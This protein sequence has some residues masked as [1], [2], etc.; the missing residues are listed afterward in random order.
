MPVLDPIALESDVRRASEGDRPAFARLIDATRTTVC[1]VALAIVR[2]VEASEDVA[3]DVYLHA[4]RSLPSLKSSASFLPWLRQLTR[5]RAHAYLRKDQPARRTNL[6]ETLATVLTD[7]RPSAEAEMLLSEERQAIRTGLDELP[8]E[9][10]EVLI[11]FYR[12]E[13]SVR[14]VANLLDLS[15]SA[16]KKRLE[17]AR[18]ALR[19]AVER[20]LS[21]A[22]D[23]TKPGA[24][25]SVTVLAMIPP[26]TP[27]IAATA[28][29]ALGAAGLSKLVAVLGS[30]ALSSLLGVVSV[31][32]GVRC[33]MRKAKE[34]SERQALRRVAVW[35]VA[36][37]A[38]LGAAMPFAAHHSERPL[39]ILA[40]FGTFLTFLWA[41]SI[42]FPAR[43]YAPRKA[44]ERAEDPTAV[45]RQRRERWRANI[46]FTL[47][48]LIGSLSIGWTI[49][50][51][52]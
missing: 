17:R 13:Q 37:M 44:R 50:H 15:E 38:L 3:Q 9:A 25:F 42:Y 1:S 19:D 36:G 31:L 46:A 10:R 40:W 49:L 6:D 32:L 16:V 41:V 5:N 34:E 51:P 24:A 30:V 21:S 4:W 48:A 29:A 18:Y 43:I 35:G 7:G 14:Q 33:E 47:G 22:L 52:K 11:L 45:R 12:E 26:A 28:K 23:R 2:D 8:A 27:T 39:P 20:T